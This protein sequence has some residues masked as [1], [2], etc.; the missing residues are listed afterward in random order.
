M[1]S[2]PAAYEYSRRGGHLWVLCDEPVSAKTGRIYLY[3]ILDRLGYPILGARGN[4]EGVEVFPKQE[5]LEVGQFGNGVR[6]PLGIHRKVKER[7]WFRDAEPN[8]E[9]QFKYLRKL[10]RVTR[11]KLEALTDGMDMPEDLMPKPFVPPAYVEPLNPFEQFDIRRYN[12]AAAGNK[13]NYMTRCPSCAAA[14]RDRRGDNLHISPSKD[15]KKRMLGIPDFYCHGALKCSFKDIV[16]ACG[17]R[18]GRPV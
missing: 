18:P 16:R 12:A 5:S 6:A 9:A 8:L 7:F 10:P 13:V 15:P 1:G 17:W 14:G 4:K 2:R 3:D 11:E